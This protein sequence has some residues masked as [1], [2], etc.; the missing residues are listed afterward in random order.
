MPNDNN[1]VDISALLS[2]QD[3]PPAD[4]MTEET[5]T[6]C[7]DMALRIALGVREV[8]AGGDQVLFISIN[9]RFISGLWTRLS[10]MTD[11]AYPQV[12]RDNITLLEDPAV[13]KAT[14]VTVGNLE[15]QFLRSH[16]TENGFLP[17][18]EVFMQGS[19]INVNVSGQQHTLGI[20]V[21]LSID[22]MRT[23]YFL[24]MKER[25]MPPRI[26]VPPMG[27]RI[28]TNLRER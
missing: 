5:D 10:A 6:I 18:L 19:H 2:S 11:E 13:E 28:E 25:L 3:E 21:R 22:T 27:A 9:P 20:P 26:V 16:F 24:E 17:R 4:T 12:F 23:L 15:E 1:T 14:F 7:D 8:T